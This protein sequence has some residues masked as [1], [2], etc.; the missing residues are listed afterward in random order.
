MLEPTVIHLIQNLERYGTLLS[1][2]E[3]E[4]PAYGLTYNSITYRF[5]RIK[6]IKHKSLLYK[7]VMAD[8]NYIQYALLGRL[9]NVEQ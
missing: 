7:V 6:I 5:L 1:D 4:S 9:W 2:D 3:V 8:G